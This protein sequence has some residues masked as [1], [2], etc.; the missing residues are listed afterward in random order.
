MLH[1]AFDELTIRTRGRGWYEFTDA[2][3]ARVAKQGFKF[4]GE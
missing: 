2:V 1:Q 4:A 3:S